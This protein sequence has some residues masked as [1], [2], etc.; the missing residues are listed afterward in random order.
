MCESYGANAN[1]QNNGSAFELYDLTNSAAVSG[2]S[3]SLASWPFNMN[4]TYW[5]S[6]VL[7]PCSLQAG[8]ANTVTTQRRFQIWG[9]STQSGSTTTLINQ[10]YCTATEYF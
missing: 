2:A 9:V 5:G 7:S 4:V 10:Q 8:I 3:T 1:T 6:S